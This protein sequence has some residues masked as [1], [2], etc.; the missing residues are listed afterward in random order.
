M[1]GVH[2]TCDVWAYDERPSASLWNLEL[3]AVFRT[4][5]MNHRRFDLEGVA[6]KRSKMIC[7]DDEE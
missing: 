1:C 2:D 7:R 5:L 4:F 3:I 6:T